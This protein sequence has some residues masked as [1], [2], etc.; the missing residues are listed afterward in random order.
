MSVVNP[1]GGVGEDDSPAV[2]PPALAIGDTAV[3]VE[4][5]EDFGDE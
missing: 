2:T 5:D 4:D 3:F 1:M